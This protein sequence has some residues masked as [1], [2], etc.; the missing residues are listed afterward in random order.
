[1]QFSCRFSFSLNV[2]MA[3]YLVCRYYLILRIADAG[4]GA[5]QRFG[6][7]RS[8]SMSIVV[9]VMRGNTISQTGISRYD[10][11]TP[12]RLAGMFSMMHCPIHRTH[13]AAM[14]IV[15]SM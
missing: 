2:E 8:G 4:W 15:A 7:G 9:S 6:L 10:C 11:V 1:M 13:I 3:G 5:Y 12:Q 14:A